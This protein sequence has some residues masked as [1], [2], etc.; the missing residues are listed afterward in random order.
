M[1][2]HRIV[3]AIATAALVTGMA[4]GGA[5]SAEAATR[6]GFKHISAVQKG[7]KIL[8]K[9]GK[10]TNVRAFKVKVSTSPKMNRNVKTYTVSKRKTSVTISPAKYAG[11]T[12]GNY[13]F[14]RVYAYKT[15]GRVGYS[16][17]AKVRLTAVTPSTGTTSITVATYNVRTANASDSYTWAER[18]PV[19][20]SQI[21]ASGASV[22][23]IQEAGVALDDGVVGIGY[24]G[25]RHRDYYWQFE[26]LD[27]ALPDYS[28]VYSD[29]YSYGLG[30]EST[31]ILYNPSK[32]T[33]L[34]TPRTFLTP[35]KQNA[36]LA[37][38]PYAEF[39]DNATGVKFWFFA[40]HLANNASGHTESYWSTL[41]GQQADAVIALVK[42]LNAATGEEVFV[43]GDMNSNEYT[44]PSNVVDAR[45]LSAG[46]YD[47][48]ASASIKHEFYATFNG[49]AKPARSPARTD[50]IF[51]YGALYGS[52]SY[53]NW[54]QS[55]PSSDH[56]MQSA[57]LPL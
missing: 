33:L 52:Y 16:P 4:V 3:A 31:R 28:L 6:A 56:F 53:R 11:Q 43:A 25:E 8:V 10:T 36:N 7:S 34:S 45:L 32:V 22:V 1:R 46:F 35:S 37:F 41:R 40:V 29:E 55:K 26:D 23:A 18:K 42:Q 20:A 30:K 48:Y 47:A 17:Y 54:I 27:D 57:T 24:D 38:I 50:Y 19:V 44:V 2:I 14:V 9:W 51:S 5:A 15:D 12:S 13:T 49:F 21:E 39:Q